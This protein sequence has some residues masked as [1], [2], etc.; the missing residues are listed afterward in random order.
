MIVDLAVISA[1]MAIVILLLIAF[2]H[3]AGKKY[4]AKYRYIAWL[5]ISIR[6]LIPFRFDFD[7]APV[8]LSEPSVLSQPIF[9]LPLQNDEINETEYE[10]NSV[11]DSSV[12]DVT[13]TGTKDNK[14]YFL[15]LSFLLT[16]IWVAGAVVFIIYHVTIL[17][18]FNQRIKKSL[19]PAGEK[20]YKSNMI[21]HPMMTGFFSKRILIPD[22]DL[23][24]DEI[25]LIVLHENVHYSRKDIWYKLMLVIA[26]AVHWFNPF[27]YFMTRY[28]NRDL[29][30][31]CD[32]IATKNMN[33]EDK[34]KYSMV[35]LKIMNTYGKKEDAK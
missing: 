30:Y 15:S 10:K 13:N 16:A 21:D 9:D 32:D 12:K 19:V 25:D 31:S 1:T 8:T 17:V 18:V 22:I 4:K 3:F 29:E 7:T 20:I 34:K 6:L 26:N 35:L 2:T 5:L 14:G 24:Q 33:L 27:V 28:A 23:N 11:T